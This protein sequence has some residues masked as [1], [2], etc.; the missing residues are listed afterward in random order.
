M[1]HKVL[2]VVF[3]I[4]TFSTGLF[5]QAD[6]C[7]GKEDTVYS[8]VLQEERKYWIHL[9]E[10]YADSVQ[11]HYPVIYLLDGDLFFHA[12]VAVQRSYSRGRQPVMPECIIVGILNTNRTR[13]YTPSKSAYRRDGKRYAGDKEVGGGSESFTVYLRD[14]LRKKIDKTYRTNNFNIIIGHS[15]GG[16]FVM[17]TLLLHSELFNIYVAL[18]PSFWWDNGKL[19]K[20]ADKLFDTKQF[21]Q[22]KLYLAIAAKTRP[23]VN[24]IH[25]NTADDFINKTLPKGI[26]NGLNVE[27]KIF[28]DESH[29]TIPIPGM[30]NALKG[31][32]DL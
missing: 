8:H 10:N 11:K 3:G 25:L 12:L 26:K 18:D 31:I 14:E 30:A 27:Y 4:A 1:R 5:A 9:P 15:F 24:N 17:N 32:L 28:P 7:I 6:I 20:D 21:N 2:L 16:L 23:E 19:Q 13:D 22:I 29:G